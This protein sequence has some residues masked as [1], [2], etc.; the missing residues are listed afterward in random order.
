MVLADPD[1]AVSRPDDT[2]LIV[3]GE[4]TPFSQSAGDFV[5]TTV[6]AD[7][8]DFD[9]DADLVAEGGVTLGP[10]DIGGASALAGGVAS[11]DGNPLAVTVE[12]LADDG[13][14]LFTRAFGGGSD[15]EVQLLDVSV[16]SDRFQI[17][18]E[19]DSGAAQNNV[20]GTFNAH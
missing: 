8:R 17:R 3:G 20:T 5:V 13:S 19:D 2:Q 6:P 14:V 9:V 1:S 4:G 15:T 16:F 10:V 7:R 18:I 12:W 11:D